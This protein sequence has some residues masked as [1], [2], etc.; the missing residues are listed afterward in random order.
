MKEINLIPQD[1]VRRKQTR[2]RT[3][4]WTLLVCASAAMIGSLAYKFEG[5][6]SAAKK[7]AAALEEK[8]QMVADIR[9]QLQQVNA[10]KARVVKHL[11][12]LYVPLQKQV[13]A[14]LLHVVSSCSGGNI[15]LTE[16]VIGQADRADPLS[17][18]QRKSTTETSPTALVL[19]GYTLAQRDLT[20][21]V[22]ALSDSKRF[23]S[24]RLKV[25]RLEQI[26]ETR[27]V[28]F[29]IECEPAAMR[30]ET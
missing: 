25:W 1:Y 21:F 12:A 29:E 7:E 13:V 4:V 2:R 14:E 23:A 20:D 30:Q 17:V 11:K 8:V 16:A 19:K 28:S 6:V 22:S 15:F 24:V 9:T 10:D 26:E 18:L 5:K 3:M 27:I